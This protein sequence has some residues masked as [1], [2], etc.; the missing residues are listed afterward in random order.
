MK[1]LQ[2]SAYFPPFLGGSEGYCYQL[3]KRLAAR[4]H[5][6]TVLTSKLDR[7]TNTR[8]MMDGFTVWR[9]P[10]LGVFWG[11]N[12]ATFILNK[13]LSQE[14]DIVHS[15]S[16][17]FLTSNQAALA[18][19]LVKT[20]L[21]LHLHGGLD[22]RALTSDFSTRFKFH[23]KKRIYDQT[24]GRWT[25]QA[26]DALASVSRRDLQLA[27]ELWHIN[28][29]K[30]NWVPNAVDPVTFN[31]N[32][33]N[34]GLNVVFV[35]RLEPWKG[36]RTFLEVADI[37]RTKRND[38]SFVIAGDGSLSQYVREFSRTHGIKHLGQVPHS[39][40]PAI[41]H[42]SSVLVL[43]SYMEGLPTVCLEAL[44]SGVPVVASRVGGTS[45]VVIDGETGYLFD[46]GNAR[47]CAEGALRLLSDEKLRVRMGEEGRKLVVGD[48][49]WETVLGK[50]EGIY[51]ALRL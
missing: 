17:I 14:F 26:S 36:I 16:Y 18:R 35:G 48:Y 51:E 50:I 27:K 22:A 49:N 2:V 34:D 11:M 10:C 24:L 23:L 38:V 42:E 8:E 19:N 28:K 32:N 31:G 20:P 29:E 40:V 25:A 15:H 45:E 3:S 4:G 12:P 6:V 13:L 43:P 46:P 30:L 47:S 44:A 1:I 37:I 21:V 7:N 41:L 33:H 5:Q 39:L 9:Q